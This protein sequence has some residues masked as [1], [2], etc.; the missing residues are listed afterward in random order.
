MAPSG[1]ERAYAFLKENYLADPDRQGEFIN[2]QEVA[3]RIGVSR[4]PIREAL[5]L[6]AAEEL[7]QLIPKR[8][9]YVAPMTGR[10]IGELME[11]R[12][13]VERHAAERTLARGEP[14]LAAMRAALEKQAGLRGAEQAREFIA[15]D[16]RFHSE[17]VAANGNEMLTKLYD[18][19]R[20]RQIR[21]GVVA[22][23]SATGRQDAVLD[24]H[25]RIL[26]ALASGDAAA[27]AAAIDTHLEATL[28]VLLD[29]A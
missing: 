9:A 3:D 14:P 18:G 7:V 5:F 10:E 16:H 1:R 11:L 20:A 12:G 22:V 17:L 19:L 4:T 27:A 23:F 26:R 28:R 25:E 2:E 24:E 13:M 6:L 29:T 15:W 8:G 21:A